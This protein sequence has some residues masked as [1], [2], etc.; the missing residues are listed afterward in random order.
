ME[1]PKLRSTASRIVV[2]HIIAVALTA[3]FM[4][5]VLFWLLNRETDSLHQRAMEDQV[6]TIA[7]VLSVS[8]DGQMALA[9]TPA[10]KAQF[11]A[12]YG[13]YFYAVL[14]P[15]GKVLFSSEQ[16]PTPI[17]PLDSFSPSSEIREVQRGDKVILGVS[18]R[19]QVDGRPVIVQVGED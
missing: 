9:L 17:Y 2:L 7:H 3:V 4:P 11:S 13:R 10:L 16:N 12:D 14:D 8:P 19:R 6:K 1:V 5:L 18:A 15:A